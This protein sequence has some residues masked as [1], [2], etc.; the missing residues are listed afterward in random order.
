MIV[1]SLAV[2]LAVP[3]PVID[4]CPLSVIPFVIVIP[5]DHVNVPEES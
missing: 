4:V 1:K 5:V 3:A 2:G